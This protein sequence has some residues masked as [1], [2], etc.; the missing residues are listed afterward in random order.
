M[1]RKFRFFAALAFKNLARH[2]RR[3]IITACVISFSIMAYVG[4]DSIMAGFESESDR[5]L[6][7]YELGNAAITGAGYWEERDQYPLDMVV[8]DADTLLARLDA[9]NIP[10]AP[11][12]MF[13]GELIIHYDPF[14]EDGSIP[15]GFLAIDPLRDDRVFRLQQSI[16]EGRTL[17][18][19]REEALI[20]RWLA[21]RIGAEVGYP[22]SVSTRTRDGFR[23]LIDLEI[24]GIYET[25]NP[26]I[27][28]NIIHIPHRIADS[29]LEM[30]GAV[31][32]IHA[33]LPENVPGTAATT[34]ILDALDMRRYPGLAVLSFS[35]MT[36]EFA[37]VT[38][39]QN[40]VTQMLLGLLAIIA[41]VGVS[42]TMLM[43]VL[44][45]EQEIGTL[46]SFGLYNGEL[47]WMFVLEAA[48]I[49]V[50][51]AIGGG[52]LSVAIL[53]LLTTRGID[54]GFLLDDIDIGYRFEGILYGVWNTDTIAY[55]SVLAI[56]V[57]GI[58]A[59]VPLRKILRK[60]I[61]ACLRHS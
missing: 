19:D 55:A 32:A 42:N 23:Q 11:R 4:L 58:V 3:T 22:V 24:V 41:L 33:T 35:D 56:L 18:P 27:D 28:R 16:R 34:P 21:D 13:R 43:S 30:R 15:V 26:H 25:S 17:D 57:A 59:V 54:Y 36:P 47:R 2:R 45:R 61:T 60:Q 20:G 6:I 8:E 46:R 37:E 7:Q 1:R 44:E 12:T 50:I 49:G 10:A 48:G 39:V 40:S 52:V 38:Q 14:P 29:Y 53:W 9:A 5:N 31:T 51:G